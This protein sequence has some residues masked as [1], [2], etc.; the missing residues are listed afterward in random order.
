MDGYSTALERVVRTLGVPGAHFGEA[1]LPARLLDVGMGVAVARRTVFRT[2]DAARNKLEQ[3]QGR[4]VRT[5]RIGPR[6]APVVRIS[7]QLR[8]V[9]ESAQPKVIELGKDFPGTAFKDCAS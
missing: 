9:L 6:S 8:D 1:K 2:E 5:A 4:G 3:L 7:L